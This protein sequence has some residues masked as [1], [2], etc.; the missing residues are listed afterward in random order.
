MVQCNQF[1]VSF[2]DSVLVDGKGGERPLP[3][4]WEL[5]KAML[6]V[7][8]GEVLQRCREGVP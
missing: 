4:D 1:L 8:L 5:E 2:V 7:N 3:P 6:T